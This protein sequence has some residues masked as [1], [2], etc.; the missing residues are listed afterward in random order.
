M[1]SLWLPGFSPGRALA[2]L[3]TYFS[4]KWPETFGQTYGWEFNSMAVQQSLAPND[5]SQRIRIHF[6]TIGQSTDLLSVLCTVKCCFSIASSTRFDNTIVCDGG[7]DFQLQK[8][9]PSLSWKKTFI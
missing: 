3:I 5:R 9:P 8:V 7:V 4:Q 1:F 6:C 2:V